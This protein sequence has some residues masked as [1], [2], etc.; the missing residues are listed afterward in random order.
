MALLI[1]FLFILDDLIFCFKVVIDRA[2]FL[3]SVLKQRGHATRHCYCWSAS[4]EANAHE[5]ESRPFSFHNLHGHPEDRR[6]VLKATGNKRFERVEF[7]GPFFFSIS[8]LEWG[9]LVYNRVLSQ[10]SMHC[11]T[12]LFEVFVFIL[13][14]LIFCFKVI[15]RAIFLASVLKQRGYAN[16]TLL[17][18]ISEHGSKCTWSWKSSIFIP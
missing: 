13:D 15:N 3:A 14:G 18:L 16:A 10:G 8:S 11:C 9:S 4:T 5:V 1:V 6:T 7:F 12:P 2:I 17:L